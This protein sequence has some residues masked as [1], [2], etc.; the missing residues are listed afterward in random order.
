MVMWQGR[1]IHL[2]Y[3]GAVP[4]IVW[5]AFASA[6]LFGLVPSPL[7]SQEQHV[8]VRQVLVG[9]L[10][11]PWIHTGASRI[12]TLPFVVF[13]FQTTADH[14]SCRHVVLASSFR[15]QAQMCC[16]ARA[17]VEMRSFDSSRVAKRSRRHSRTCGEETL[18][19]KEET[20]PQWY[21]YTLVG[22]RG[23]RVEVEGRADGHRWVYEKIHPR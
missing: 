10:N 22:L 9:V 11:Q 5:I 6:A 2:C 18:Q 12:P 8:V 23:K 7:S 4:S 21:R 14:G 20:H 19:G 1:F 17:H 16:T 13:S 3:A 15:S